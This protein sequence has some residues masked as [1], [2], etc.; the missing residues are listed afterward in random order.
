MDKEFAKSWSLVKH[1]LTRYS[2]TSKWSI[3][4]GSV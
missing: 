2:E 3:F 1:C 4:Y